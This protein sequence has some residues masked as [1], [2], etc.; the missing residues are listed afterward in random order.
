[1]NIRYGFLPIYKPSPSSHS[2]I[3]KDVVRE[4]AQLPLEGP[5]IGTSISAGL[6]VYRE[7]S[8][9]GIA[10][11]LASRCVE[12]YSVPSIVLVPSTIPGQV[13]G[14]YTKEID[15]THDIRRM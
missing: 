11:L 4:I 3:G 8:P 14:S 7:L 9:K 15:I 12:G 10:G 13:V 5:R 6:V 2:P 1:M